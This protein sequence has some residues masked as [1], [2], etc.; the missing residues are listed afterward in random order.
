VNEPFGQE[1][2]YRGTT[3]RSVLE[4]QWAAYFDS[5][6]CRWRYE[7]GRARFSGTVWTPDFVIGENLHLVVECK[8]SHFLRIDKVGKFVLSQRRPVLLALEDGRFALCSYPSADEGRFATAL[9]SSETSEIGYAS[10]FRASLHLDENH[11]FL[12]FT[13]D[14]DQSDAYTG[15]APDYSWS[16]K[17]RSDPWGGDV[18]SQY[19]GG[20]STWEQRGFDRS[21][22]L[23]RRKPEWFRKA[24]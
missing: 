17:D 4:A 7:P 2:F 13:N 24:G 19:Y 15:G 14:G 6:S 16:F 18:R 10:R 8:G 23:I 20:R 5:I 9:S 11:L 22:V 12:N 3:F 21:S 1:C